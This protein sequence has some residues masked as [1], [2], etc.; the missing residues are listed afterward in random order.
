MPDE[1]HSQ[2]LS[3]KRKLELMYNVH[4]FPFQTIN[5]CLQF[6]IERRVLDEVFCDNMFKNKFIINTEHMP[7]DVYT[8][9]NGNLHAWLHVIRFGQFV[10]PDL[11]ADIVGE[12]YSIFPEVE[13]LI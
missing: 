13:M 7:D 11:L 8:Y 4:E 6:N 9:I 3:Q 10:G 1:L 2:D 5:I 12:I